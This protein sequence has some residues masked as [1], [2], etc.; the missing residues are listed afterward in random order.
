MMCRAFCA[1][2]RTP[3]RLHSL[4]RPRNRP[5]T[6]TAAP[7]PPATCSPPAHPARPQLLKTEYDTG[8]IVFNRFVSAISQKPTIATVL[9]PDVSV[10]HP[11]PPL[12]PSLPP[13][14]LCCRPAHQHRCPLRGC[15]AVSP[16]ACL[17]ACLPAR[18]TALTHPPTPLRFPCRRRSLWSVRP[19]RA[20]PSTSTS[21]R[22]PTAPRCSWTSPSSSS[23]RCCTTACWRTTAR[24]SRRA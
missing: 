15:A 5:L 23:P 13:R 11:P 8:R 18:P 3:L 16:L 22:G 24:S 17:P 21:W 9:S 1:C 7:C 14:L 20:L 2:I 12:P 4:T 6:A 19:R 10:K